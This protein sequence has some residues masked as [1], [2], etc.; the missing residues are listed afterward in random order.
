MNRSRLAALTAGAMFLVASVLVPATAF[1]A[2]PTGVLSFDGVG[3]GPVAIATTGGSTFSV[4]IWAASPAG[5]NPAGASAGVDYDPSQLKLLSV[6]KGADWDMP[7]VTWVLPSASD[8][9]TANATGTLPAIAAFFT[10]G[11]S[12]AADG[13]ALRLAHLTF[14]QTSCGTSTISLPVTGSNAGG[15]LDGTP[16]AGHTYGSG[17]DATSQPANVTCSGGSTGGS[18]TTNVT[19]TV[20]TGFVSLTCPASVTVPLVRNV[21]N[22]ANFECVIGANVTWTLNA[23][24]TNADPATHGYMRDTVQGI[25]LHDSAF[26]NSVNLAGSLSAQA[27]ATGQNN[28]N[29]PM[30]FSQFA[31]PTD[32]AGSYGMQVLFSAVSSF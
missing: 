18:V 25:H 12:Y 22:V 20:D 10:D 23:L 5:I 26:V 1:A 16:G 17:V 24:D 8:I 11:T 28:V 30:T 21:N 27:V 6:T 13:D 9:A 2:G 3:S 32:K 15:F 14:L 31:E 19:G 4:D 7:G 29:V